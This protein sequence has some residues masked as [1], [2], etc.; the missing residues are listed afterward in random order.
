MNCPERFRRFYSHRLQNGDAPASPTLLSPPEERG[1][2]RSPDEGGWYFT[3]FNTRSPDG[4]VGQRKVGNSLIS[5]FDLRT[6]PDD[7][8]Q[9]KIHGH[10]AHRAS[11]KEE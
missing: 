5:N 10:V 7:G 2:S 4:S 1:G 6:D 11:D 3:E 9:S 8:E